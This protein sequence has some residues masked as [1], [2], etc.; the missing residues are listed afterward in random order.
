MVGVYEAIWASC[1]KQQLDKELIKALV[2][3]WSP[4]ANNFLTCYEELDITLKDAY[5]STRLPIME[6]MYDEFF[7]TNN[8]I[9]DEMLHGTLK[10]FFLV[11]DTLTK[12]DEAAQIPIMGEGV[13]SRTS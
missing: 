10:C 4:W 8:L 3:R 1:Y 5:R 11:M 7:L 9:F 12:R 13:Y 2:A 6:N